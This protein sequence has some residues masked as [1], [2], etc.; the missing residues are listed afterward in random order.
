MNSLSIS[1]LFCLRLR[2]FVEN[3]LT[4]KVT[5]KL[6]LFA[7]LSLTFAMNQRAVAQQF[8][9]QNPA[10]PAE[11]R[12]ADLAGRLSLEQKVS[13]MLY[14]SPAIPEFGIHKYNWWN[15]A[16]HGCARSGLATVFPQA[17]G[18]AAS[19]D[20]VLL[21]KVFGIASTE[22]RIK[23]NQARAKDDVTIYHGLTV[24]TP[25]INIFR[26]PRWGRGQE[27]Y[28][29]DPYLTATMGAA[30]VR[31]LQGPSDAGY[32]KLHACVKHFAV[33]SGPEYSRHKF[34]VEE[35][36]L[37]D[38]RETYLYAFKSIVQTTDVKQ[39][40]CAYNA[41]EGKPCCSS[42]KLLT[43]I[44]RNDWGYRNLVVTDC[45]AINDTFQSY[46]HNKFPGNPSAA[47]AAAVRSGADLECGESFANLV[48]AV[49]DGELTEE[50][51]NISVTRV[52]K[53][54]F[55]L[56]EMD[57][58]EIVSWST[59]PESLLACTA[60]RDCALEMARETMT[61]L[62]N[63]G[64]LP[65]SKD[66]K[67]VVIGPN[68]AEKGI[69]WGNYEGEPYYTVSVLEG[70]RNKIGEDNVSWFKGCEIAP[71]EGTAPSKPVIDKKKIAAADVI[72]FVGGISPNL[73]GEEMDVRY[74]G[75]KGGD[76]TS[77]ELP[78][79][80]RELIAQLARCGKPLV[81]VNMSGSAVALKPEAGE[82]NAILQA[83]YGGEA[84]GTAV[85][86]VLFGD[87]NPAG[88]LPVTFYASDA[89]LVNYEDYTMDDKTY[90]YFKGQPLYPFGHGLSY[91]TFEYGKASYKDGAISFSISNTGK[92]DGDEVAQVYAV[93]NSDP[94]GPALSLRGFRRVNVP[95]GSSVELCIPL[96][97]D[98][99]DPATGKMEQT[100][101]EY[102]LWYGGTS[103]K[104][105]LKSIQI[106]L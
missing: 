6:V 85:A 90:R 65:L 5:S 73:E 31:G 57:D 79:T 26:D 45:W 86:D 52:L 23:F 27:T 82:C 68:A 95:A 30:V 93:R 81:M 44:L 71:V 51:I 4:M 62:Q 41:F 50:E 101:G 49:N 16:L 2:K 36:S 96:T 98:L 94:E 89:D 102:T 42:D 58:P 32:D 13:L 24:W 63:D 48:K 104:K 74:K 14:E 56:G 33:H 9:Y 34:N 75:F 105:G 106:T 69:L 53:S 38:L 25:N 78:A 43:R 80:Q 55:E 72:I 40:M 70:I 46:G 15:E 88:K 18:M 92:M 19:W 77:I 60:H 84:A 22:Q 99:Y 11:E 87:Y 29:E 39:V 66:K 21:E 83:W 67:V 100:P 10:L 59:L 20:K 17:I 91:T 8:P 35:L 7:T 28:G 97:L 54:R 64:V 3:L 47:V 103:D 76:R 61:L 1:F 12:A 37:R